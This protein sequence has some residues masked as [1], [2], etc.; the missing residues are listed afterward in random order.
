[1]GTNVQALEPQSWKKVPTEKACENESLGKRF[2]D[3]FGGTL[4][5]YRH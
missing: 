1:M 3:S 5:R 4:P 2:P